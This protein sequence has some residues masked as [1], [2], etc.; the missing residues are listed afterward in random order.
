MTGLLDTWV[1]QFSPIIYNIRKLLLQ[2]EIKCVWKN[3]ASLSTSLNWKIAKINLRFLNIYLVIREKK[4]HVKL[5]VSITFLWCAY[6]FKKMASQKLWRRENILYFL[7]HVW[8]LK[9]W[10]YW[11]YSHNF[12]HILHC[13]SITA[14]RL[15]CEKEPRRINVKKRF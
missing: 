9:F 4:T 2:T 8:K 11:T 13:L 12:N 6:F 1:V 10:R 7:Q 14:K 5:H 15:L 3:I